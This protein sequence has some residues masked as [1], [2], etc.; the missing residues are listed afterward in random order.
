MH[1]NSFSLLLLMPRGRP[2]TSVI[3]QNMIELLFHLRKGYGYQIS[4]LYNEI[5][6][7]VT[8]RS[9]YYH[10]R[11]GIQTKEIVEHSLQRERGNFSWGS[12]VEKKIYALGEAAK[13]IGSVKVKIHVENHGTW[14]ENTGM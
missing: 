8:Q 11:K 7:P 3:R 14:K 2:T 13:P 5:F 10:L 12:E 9:I 4:K 6:P 1:I